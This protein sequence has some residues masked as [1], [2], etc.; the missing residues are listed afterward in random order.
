MVAKPG[1]CDTR[2]GL[3]AGGCGA[4]V[5]QSET[6]AEAERPGKA[7]DTGL[8]PRTRIRAGCHPV[9]EYCR[10]RETRWEAGGTTLQP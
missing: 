9:P 10:T 2:Q 5:V 6:R 1:L 4:G 8:E 7:G 3:Q